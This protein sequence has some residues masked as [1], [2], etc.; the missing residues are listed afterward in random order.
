MNYLLIDSM[1][2]FS[3]FTNPAGS[4]RLPA[5]G[6]QRL[7]EQDLREVAEAPLLRFLRSAAARADGAGFSSRMGFAAGAFWP[8]AFSMR[9]RLAR[10]VV[11]VGD[12]AR[13]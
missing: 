4:S 10:E 2:W 3:R 12:E 13:R 1:S 11:L 5:F 8:A 7:V 9:C 6:Q